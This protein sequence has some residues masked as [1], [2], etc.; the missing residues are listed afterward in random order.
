MLPL[1]TGLALLCALWT[2][3]PIS[4]EPMSLTSA[5]PAALPAAKTLLVG[6]RSVKG[7]TITAFD[8]AWLTTNGVRIT[9]TARRE[10]LD[11]RDVLIRLQVWPLQPGIDLHTE[12]TLDA[13]TL[14]TVSLHR[15]VK[16]LPEG[17]GLG[18]KPIISHW[19][20]DG[21]DYTLSVTHSDE[22]VV[23]HGA[24]DQPMFDGGG[25]GLVI[26]AL[27]LKAG[28]E[29]R[30]PIAMP[31]D[32]APELTR[33]WAIVRVNGRESVTG[34]D[35]KDVRAWVV[36]VDWA[37]YD[38]DEITSKGGAE[39]S[40]GAYYVVPRPPE[41]FPFVPRYV[42]AGSSIDVVVEGE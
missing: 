20:F 21:A 33:Y 15:E 12:L 16:G 22:P 7:K 31:L 34:P 24:L 27:P 4:T 30:I 13:K 1:P 19:D 18:E 28:Y 8:N 23:S 38:T 3:D 25:L 32:L 41:G 26:A 5:A 36:D 6:D 11:G 39:E 37:D 35:G 9:E 2:A 42:N 40:G 17:A 29:A 10:T 14:E